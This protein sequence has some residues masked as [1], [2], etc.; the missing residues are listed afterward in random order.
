MRREAWQSL[1]LPPAAFSITPKRISASA[2][3]FLGI[4]TAVQ[5]GNGK[6]FDSG[7]HTAAAED[8]GAWAVWRA[9]RHLGISY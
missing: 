6:G 4:E 2:S 9:D 8:S 5:S 7:I 3:I 1:C